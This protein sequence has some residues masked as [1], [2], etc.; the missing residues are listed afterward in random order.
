MKINYIKYDNGLI[1]KISNDFLINGK[2]LE[3]SFNSGWMFLPEETEIKTVQKIKPSKSTNFRY[4]LIDK[5]F[6]RGND[7]PFSIKVE[8][9]KYLFYSDEAYEWVFRDE[10]K[11]LSSL[12]KLKFDKIEESYEDIIDFEIVLIATISSNFGKTEFKV[13]YYSELYN[14]GAN[15]KYLSNSLI[16]TD[17]VSSIVFPDVM[18][19][20]L[21]C[22]IDGNVMYKIVRAYVKQ[23]IDPKYAS[24]TSDY[25]FCFVVEKKLN[26]FEIEEYTVDVNNS[27]FNKRKRKPKFEKRYRKD[28]RVICFE[29]TPP[30][31]KYE[32]YTP[33]G[34]V[35]GTDYKDLEKNILEKCEEIITIINEPLCDCPFCKGQGVVTESESNKIKNH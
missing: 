26:L 23:N 7:V 17:Y 25:D 33:M 24:I 19:D 27:I 8:D 34:G 18:K 16:K 11:H 3:P 31:K 4:E 15:I 35:C 5:S 30:S 10:Y 28:R 22:S 9:N 12:Y 6:E 21:P 2:N 29:M 32:H 13:K 1:L 20:N 14:G